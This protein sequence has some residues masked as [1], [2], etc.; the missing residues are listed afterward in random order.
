MWWVSEPQQASSPETTTS[1][2]RRVEQADGR[3]IDAGVEHALHAAHEERDA[4]L[5]FAGSRIGAGPAEAL[6]RGQRDAGTRP[7]NASMRVAPK[8]CTTGRN[9]RAM[10]A[11]ISAR[12]N[13]RGRGMA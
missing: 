8:D 9:G 4:A 3:G 7:S 2:P 1:M 5:P 6:G 12:R 11:A 10:R 13:S